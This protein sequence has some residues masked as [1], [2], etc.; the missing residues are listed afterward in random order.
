MKNGFQAAANSAR[1]RS[2]RRRGHSVPLRNISCEIARH[3][4]FCTF[5]HFAISCKKSCW[6]FI[7]HFIPGKFCLVQNPQSRASSFRQIPLNST[8]NARNSTK[9]H[10]L[11]LGKISHSTSLV[12]LG[13]LAFLV[14]QNVAAPKQSLFNGRNLDGFYTWLAD[15]QYKDPRNVF[16]VT[17]GQIRISGEGLGY[18]ATTNSHSNYHL[19]LEFRWGNQNW[20][21]GGR[22]GKARDSGLFL[23]AT[24]PDGNSHDGNGAFMAAIECNIFQG[25][26]GDFLLIRGDDAEGKLIPPRVTAPVAPQKDADGW[27]TYQP[28]GEPAT[29][30]RWG[31]INW[32]HK[33][34]HWQD[35]TDFRG[36]RD[37]EHAPGQW[38]KLEA[39]CKQD[40]IEIRLNGETVNRA[41][42]V[43]PASGKILLQCEGSEI[44]FRNLELVPLESGP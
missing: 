4:T 27:F 17:N 10:F 25:A 32:S 38:N 15:T 20:H 29:I 22:I 9:F 44:Y 11:P 34:P 6:P 30:E 28:G 2:V 43:W 41:T 40:T 12:A 7:Q 42:K 39:I 16:T 24:G 23:H 21:Y 13:L 3:F 37:V 35:K 5:F 14:S 1:T 18:L 26:T 19:T 8:E 36:P 31:R 33:S